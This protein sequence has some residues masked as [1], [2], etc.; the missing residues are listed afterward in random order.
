[1]LKSDLTLSDQMEVNAGGKA[2]D[3][4]LYHFGKVT[5]SDNAKLNAILY[6]NAGDLVMS[7]QAQLTGAVSAVNVTMTNNS[8]VI[9]EPFTG[10][11]PG[12]CE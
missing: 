5:M 3:L 11:W 2:N 12:I 7:G 6:V 8:K 9:H 4:M 10:D 1:Y